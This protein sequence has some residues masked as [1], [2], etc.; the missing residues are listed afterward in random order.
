MGAL[1]REAA[2]KNQP[3]S[4]GRRAPADG[5]ADKDLACGAPKLGNSEGLPKSQ[6]PPPQAVTALRVGRAPG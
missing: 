3:C 5:E 6:G 4:A 1:G 2:G